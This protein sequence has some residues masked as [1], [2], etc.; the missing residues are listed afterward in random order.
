MAV[1]GQAFQERSRHSLGTDSKKGDSTLST[2][3]TGTGHETLVNMTG[4]GAG[5]TA[6]PSQA[7][8]KDF[9]PG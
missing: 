8:G 3:S 9:E 7:P 2:P 1:E 4:A 6:G 5:G